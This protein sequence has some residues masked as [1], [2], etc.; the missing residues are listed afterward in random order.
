M[1]GHFSMSCAKQKESGNEMYNDPT[2][3]AAAGLGSGA[4]AFTGAGEVFWFGLAAFAML[5]AGMA[6]AR[7]LPRSEEV[8]D[9]NE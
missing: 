8:S 9:Q 5:A 1:Y 6:V 2:S 3:A 7:I 4:L